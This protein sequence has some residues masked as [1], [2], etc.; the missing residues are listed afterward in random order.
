M[1]DTEVI[2]V[3]L[4]LQVRNNRQLDWSDFEAC[5]DASGTRFVTSCS[6]ETMTR[7]PNLKNVRNV[8]FWCRSLSRRMGETVDRSL[9]KHLLRMFNALGIYSESFERQFLDCTADFYA[10][11]GTRFMQQ[12][13]VPDYLKHVEVSIPVFGMIQLTFLDEWIFQVYQL[14]KMC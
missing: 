8:N 7:F 12:T 11:E 3:T 14:L 13:D 9:L 5:C 6:V 2:I 4:V 1:V 10:A